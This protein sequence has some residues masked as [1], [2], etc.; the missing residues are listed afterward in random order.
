MT[1]PEI[2]QELDS[3]RLRLRALRSKNRQ[4]KWLCLLI[5]AN[6][7]MIANTIKSIDYIQNTVKRL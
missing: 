5:K 3:I 2:I 4:A 6:E 7:E 1:A